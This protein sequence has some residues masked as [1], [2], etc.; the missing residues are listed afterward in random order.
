M[1]NS[2]SNSGTTNKKI[3]LARRKRVL[4]DS[5]IAQQDHTNAAR[6]EVASP[7]RMPLAE[8]LLSMP[9]VGMDSDFARSSDFAPR[10]D[11]QNCG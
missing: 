2:K 10:I 7:R 3:S 9:D 1:R 8:V 6:T 11:R 5:S 4:A